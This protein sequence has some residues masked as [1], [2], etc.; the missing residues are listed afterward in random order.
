MKTNTGYTYPP[1]YGNWL[2]MRA[3]CNDRHNK[4]WPRYGG[5]GIKVC[6]RWS[7]RIH[8]FRNFLA[9]M[10]PRPPGHTIDRINNDGDYEPSNCRWGTLRQQ[11][12]NTRT[13]RFATINGETRTITEWARHYGVHDRLVWDRLKHGWDLERALTAPKDRAKGGKV[14]TA[15]LTAEQVLALRADRAAGLSLPKLAAKYG[16]S[17]TATWHICQRR[18]WAHI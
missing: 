17:V 8:G 9:D 1:E 15:K 10:G 5:R 2:S 14:N 4:D 12:N 7:V 18:N 16:L 3:R 11:G 13:N 6:E